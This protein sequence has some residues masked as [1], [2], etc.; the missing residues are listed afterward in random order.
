MINDGGMLLTMVAIKIK[1]T[2]KLRVYNLG[3]LRI[4]NQCG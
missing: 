2:Q 3:T 4:R 1:N